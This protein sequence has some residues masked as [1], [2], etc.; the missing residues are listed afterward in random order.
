VSAPSNKSLGAK[1]ELYRCVMSWP[2]RAA[3]STQAVIG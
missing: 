2:Y 3:A 1:H